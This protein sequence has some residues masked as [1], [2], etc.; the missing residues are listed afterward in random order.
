MN[1]KCS[2]PSPTFLLICLL[3][4]LHANRTRT[5]LREGGEEKGCGRLLTHHLLT[6]SE[7]SLCI[8]LFCEFYSGSTRVLLDNYRIQA[9]FFFPSL[10][11]FQSKPPLRS[12][13]VIQSETAKQIN[14]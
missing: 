12:F 14:C 7:S 2:S 3:Q 4:F 13:I 11:Q 10:S 9:N 1:C 8:C 5:T 6:N